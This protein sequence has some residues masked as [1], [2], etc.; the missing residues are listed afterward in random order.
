MTKHKIF[1]RIA[2]ILLLLEYLFYAAGF[3]FLSGSYEFK[4]LLGHKTD[5][6]MIFMDDLTEFLREGGNPTSS[7]GMKMFSVC[8][9]AMLAVCLVAYIG[10]MIF[11]KKRLPIFSTTYIV[12]AISCVV[13]LPLIW[14][15]NLSDSLYSNELLITFILAQL[16][17]GF[18][19]FVISYIVML[20]KCKSGK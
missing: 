15:C 4:S 6:D 7:P 10:F 14:Y 9:F 3:S 19:T 11:S 1:N 12:K 20:I 5:V 18:V 16:A 17:V 13:I 2:G 8:I